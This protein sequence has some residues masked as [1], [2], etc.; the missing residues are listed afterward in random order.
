[1]S[2][3]DAMN[4][5]WGPLHP[6]AALTQARLDHVEQA[7]ANSD[8]D[9]TDDDDLDSDD[10]GERIALLLH[11]FIAADDR[12][13]GAA[14]AT[15]PLIAANAWAAGADALEALV[16]RGTPEG[17]A[18]IRLMLD[19]VGFVE[20]MR[21]RVMGFEHARVRLERPGTGNVVASREL[22]V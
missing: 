21:V 11:L 2:S 6:L 19:E 22:L 13:R 14:R 18:L 17:L 5:E 20:T 10:K 1:M 16:P 8:G 12:R 9:E 3:L 7:I 4:A 15:L